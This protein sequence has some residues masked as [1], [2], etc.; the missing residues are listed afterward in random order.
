MTVQ[1]LLGN[2]ASCQ[3]EIAV[4]QGAKTS[5]RPLMEGTP[6]TWTHPLRYVGAPTKTRSAPSLA[7]SL[8]S[9]SL[10]MPCRLRR[11]PQLPPLATV[12]QLTCQRRQ[13]Y[14]YFLAKRY[15]V[16]RILQSVMLWYDLM[17]LTSTLECCT[18]TVLSTIL[19]T[20]S[21][22]MSLL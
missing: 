2:S 3:R 20:R 19:L 13:R 1:C 9:L 21:P 17:D 22:S 11:C 10:T 16:L 6:Y 5:Q 12:A 4:K 18:E 7:A 14:W 8:P 15:V